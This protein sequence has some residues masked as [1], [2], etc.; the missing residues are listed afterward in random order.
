MQPWGL[1]GTQTKAVF[2]SYG[3]KESGHP[4]HPANCKILWKL[5]GLSASED[6][7]KLALQC[8]LLG[9]DSAL[10]ELDCTALALNALSE[11]WDTCT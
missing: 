2:R 11:T 5:V 1:E 4:G 3:G 9:C 6:W 8:F 10:E 7:Q